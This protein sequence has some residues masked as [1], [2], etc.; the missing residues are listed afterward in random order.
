MFKSMARVTDESLAAY[1]KVERPTWVTQW[2]GQVVIMV[3]Q[4]DW[5]ASI[6]S[7]LSSE[8]DENNKVA[9][10]AEPSRV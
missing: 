2:Q 4:M 5:T 10:P 9:W 8:D 7:A 3:G 1:A 6:D